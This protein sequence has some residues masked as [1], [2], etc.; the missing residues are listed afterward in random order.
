MVYFMVFSGA[1][2]HKNGDTMGGESV[3]SWYFW[4]SPEAGY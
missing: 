1:L 4:R 2:N 3:Q